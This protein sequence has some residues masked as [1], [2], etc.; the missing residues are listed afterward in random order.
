ML[1]NFLQTFRAKSDPV[2]DIDFSGQWIDKLDSSLCLEVSPAGEVSG[3][4]E[5]SAGSEEMRQS[6][7]LVGFAEGDLIAFTVSFEKSGAIAAW[8]G[9]Y[10]KAGYDETIQTSWHLIRNAESGTLSEPIWGMVLT[11]SSVFRR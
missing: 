3:K 4:Y 6:S 1:S 5:S 8:V 9:Q 2:P 7:G 11:G 10:V